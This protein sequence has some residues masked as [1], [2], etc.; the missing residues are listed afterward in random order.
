MA[1]GSR[2]TGRVRVRLN[3][4]AYP[5]QASLGVLGRKWALLILMNIALSRAQ[6]FNE[7]LRSAPGMNRRVLVMRLRELERDGFIERG[8]TWQGYS[9]WE[10]TKKGADVLPVLL[11][12]IHFASRWRVAGASPLVPSALEGEPFEIRYRPSAPGTSKLLP[13]ATEASPAR[14]TRRRTA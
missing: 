5:V 8:E 9:R 6:R 12:L 2:R 11:T 10:L 13:A 14:R 4:S 1:S 7:I 3:F